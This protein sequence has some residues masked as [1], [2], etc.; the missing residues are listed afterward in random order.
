MATPLSMVVN[1][2]SNQRR[3]IRSLHQVLFSV[4]TVY[5]DGCSRSD[6]F[7]AGSQ[8]DST[9]LRTRTGHSVSGDICLAN[10]HRRFP[11]CLQR[12]HSIGFTCAL[13]LSPHLRSRPPPKPFLGIVLLVGILT[14]W[15]ESY[16]AKNL[17]EHD[18]CP[19]ILS[20]CRRAGWVHQGEKRGV[21]TIPRRNFGVHQGGTVAWTLPWR[22]PR[23]TRTVPS[24]P[25]VEPGAAQLCR[26]GEREGTRRV[27]PTVAH[28]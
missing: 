19:R 1:K 6:I 2:T 13:Q 5:N 21:S 20:H 9:P 12:Y 23:M 25:L 10:S 17:E 16:D 15:V 24:H 27:N 8:R 4:H 11:I 18:L 28:R 22:L 7:D 3:Q 26:P 14:R